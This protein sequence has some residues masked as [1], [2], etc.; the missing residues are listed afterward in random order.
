MLLPFVVSLTSLLALKLAEVH[1]VYLSL[2]AQIC[3]FHLKFR[4]FVFCFP[5]T[6]N[7]SLMFRPSVGRL[8]LVEKAETILFDYCEMR[9]KSKVCI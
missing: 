3:F 5:P 6:L 1:L 7:N 8:F 2:H 9:G 4:A